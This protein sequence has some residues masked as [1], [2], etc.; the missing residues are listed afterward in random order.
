MLWFASGLAVWGQIPYSFTNLAGLPG[1]NGSILIGS[2]DGIGSGARFY[3]PQGVAEDSAGNLFVADT[4]MCVIRKVTP[5][6][7][8][9]TLAG[10]PMAS[11]I[12][13]GVGSDA[14]FSAPCGIALDSRGNLFVTDN[15]TIRKVTQ[16]GAVTTIAGL[17]GVNGNADGTGSAA[18]F[19]WPCGVAADS[20]GNIFVV[21]RGNGAI[22]KVTSD[23]V[24][25]TL[26]GGA[27]SETQFNN[28]WGVAV[29]NSGNVFVADSGNCTIRKI[30]SD[31]VVTTLAGLS[32]GTT[33]FDGYD[34]GVGSAARFN[35]PKGITIDGDGNLFVT[36]IQR[37]RKVT[38][39]GVVTTLAG[40]P[41]VWSWWS[42]PGVEGS[43]DA[44]GSPARFNI[45]S[46]IVVDR[47]G[48]L[49]VT[50]SKNNGISKG[51]PLAGIILSVPTLSFG[52]NNGRPQLEIAGTLGNSYVLECSTNLTG[53][54][55]WKPLA[56]FMLM[57]SPVFLTDKYAN[58]IQQRFYRVR[59]DY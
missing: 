14:R 33:S 41:Q 43:T 25:T 32:G 55:A 50:D 18:R 28:P 13:D 46:W 39:S 59:Q 15:N 47:T 51:M 21:D 12:T 48:N 30:T 58:G 17:A 23:G 54:G 35:F 4:L 9:T 20:T 26:A 52:W 57:N 8:V 24:V 1:S 42:W 2:P 45:A 5:L 36:D 7:V 11:D 56:E 27:G 53:N 49:Y 3:S 22:R 6:R 44:A 37:I 40:W 16:D 31:G 10:T 29:D 34:D 19:Y 38:P